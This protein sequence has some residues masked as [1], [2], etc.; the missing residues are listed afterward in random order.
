MAVDMYAMEQVPCPIDGDELINRTVTKI[1]VGHSHAACIT[2]SGELFV[3][4]MA[5][6]LEPV[7]VAEVLHTKIID[8]VC[9]NDYTMAL[10]DDHQIYVWGKGRTG[11]L[12][13]GPNTKTLYAISCIHVGGL[14]A[15]GLLSG[16]KRR[17]IKE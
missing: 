14:G 4:G 7:R 16:T 1:A 8:L 11:V 6:H 15:C 3:W 17:K 13:V 9:G 12:G 5:L 10:S 2:T